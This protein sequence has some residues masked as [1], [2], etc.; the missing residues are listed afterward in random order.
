[1]KI[2]TKKGDK[3]STGL[4]GGARV[5]KG[6]PQIEAYGTVDEL[7]SYL[8]IVI[9]YLNTKDSK[10]QLIWIQNQLFVLGSTFA[11][12]S[13]GTKMKM[14]NLSENDINQLEEWID[15]MQETLPELTHFI[16]PG[17]NLGNAHCHVARCIC[18]R[19]ERKAVEAEQDTEDW[20]IGI[21]FLNRLSDYLFVLCRK[22]SQ[23]NKTEE[24]K[25]IPV[26]K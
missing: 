3:G 25:W 20:K 7:N 6:N 19:A 26:K 21:A 11:T 16:L 23:I 15:K 12:S 18:R 24:I 17:G 2:Y 13:E 10:D 5:S 14:P 9:E 1:M 4:I 8:G 22:I